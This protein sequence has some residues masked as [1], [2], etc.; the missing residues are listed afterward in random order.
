[1]ESLDEWL[2]A[3]GEIELRRTLLHRRREL[4][5]KSKARYSATLVTDSTRLA[6]VQDLFHPVLI[7][8]RSLMK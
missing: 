1:M 8:R 7:F 6:F 4:G 2:D 3:I 5:N